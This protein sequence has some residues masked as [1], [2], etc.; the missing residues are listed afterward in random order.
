MCFYKRIFLGKKIGLYLRRLLRIRSAR[1]ERHRP[2]PVVQFTRKT[3][4]LP[5]L[6]TY[7]FRR[8]YSLFVQKIRSKVSFFSHL[9]S[10]S[11][12]VG[13]GVNRV[14]NGWMVFIDHLFSVRINLFCTLYEMR[15]FTAWIWLQA[16]C[17]KGDL[18]YN[19]R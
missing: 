12:C 14:M 2:K 9:S 1:L 16:C 10:M 7:L 11:I 4:A 13:G 19:A 18:Q 17:S 6:V 15:T 3:N 5:F 8:R